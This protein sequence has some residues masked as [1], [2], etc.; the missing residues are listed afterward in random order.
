MEEVLE[1]DLQNI[2]LRSTLPQNIGVNL[3]EYMSKVETFKI[4]I[5]DNEFVET[6]RNDIFVIFNI[7]PSKL[8][9]TSGK[10]DIVNED[11]T[12]ISSGKWIIE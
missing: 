6:A 8:N 3:S 2:K 7:D 4:I 12:Y 11:D 10:Y 5:E 9:F 1:K